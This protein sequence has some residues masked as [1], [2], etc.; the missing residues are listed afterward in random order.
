MRLIGCLV[1][2]ICIL[3]EI[4]EWMREVRIQVCEHETVTSVK[5]SYCGVFA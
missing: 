5:D 4:T 2:S 1:C 3:A